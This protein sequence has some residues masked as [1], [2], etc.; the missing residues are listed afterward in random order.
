MPALAERTER[1]FRAPGGH[2]RSMKENKQIRMTL[3]I[4]TIP[5]STVT[6]AR[7]NVDGQVH[8][9][10]VRISAKVCK[11]EL[12]IYA[13]SHVRESLCLCAALTK[14]KFPYEAYNE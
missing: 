12:Y 7:R 14:K 4:P 1:H 10:K 6:E 9:W 13:T 5:S 8:P 2:T 11:F 3:K